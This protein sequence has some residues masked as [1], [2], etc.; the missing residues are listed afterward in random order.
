MKD[1]IVETSAR[2]VHLTKEDFQILFGEGKELTVKKMLSQPGQFASN[3]RVTLVG[4]KSKIERVLILGPF[5]DKSQVELSKTDLRTL[6]IEAPV[7]LSGD[8]TNAGSVKI[9]GPNGE[10]E[11]KQN[12]VVPK[13]HIHMTTKDAE[14]FNVE[15]GESVMVKI[16]SPERA[17]IFDEC[18]VRVN[19]NFSLAMHIDTDES[20][21][22]NADM[23]TRGSIVEYAE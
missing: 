7:N 15:D 6:G 2:H 10:I 4:P 13:R 5:R 19:D 17:L 18:I 14:N 11:L 23:N 22:A 9:V 20:N 16:E 1:F 12:V 21:A 3:E 8:L